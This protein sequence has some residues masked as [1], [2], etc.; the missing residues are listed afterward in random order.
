MITGNVETADAENRSKRISIQVKE[1]HKKSQRNLNHAQ[2]NA[3]VKYGARPDRV[4]V[5]GIVMYTAP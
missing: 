5:R 4:T 1:R 3:L 2:W